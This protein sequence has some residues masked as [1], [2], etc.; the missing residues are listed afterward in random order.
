MKL[1][2]DEVVLKVKDWLE[3]NGWFV[4]DNYCIRGARG[5]D[6]KAIKND[7]L[8]IVEVKGAKARN[9][10]PTKRRDK[11][12]SGQIKN[13]FGEAIVKIFREMNNYPEAE[14]AIAH[15][16]DKDI[17][18]II[19]PLIPHLRKLNVKHYWVSSDGNLT[20]E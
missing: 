20:I 14:F 2:E 17:R 11:F 13:H 1:D 15:P 7:H 8:L 5:L 19:G 9:E 12:D 4:G 10:A 16:E 6:I 3:H 18:R